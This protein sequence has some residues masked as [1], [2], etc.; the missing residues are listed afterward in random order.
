MSQRRKR[1]RGKTNAA[2]RNSCSWDEMVGNNENA[3]LTLFTVEK[4]TGK[5]VQVDSS[6]VRWPQ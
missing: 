3:I 1:V 4:N 6:P 5:F 2:K